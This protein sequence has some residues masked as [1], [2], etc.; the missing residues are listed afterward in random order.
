MAILD[1][2]SADVVFRIEP[3]TMRRIKLRAGS[4]DLADYLWFNIIRPNV[5]SHVW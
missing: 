2:G 3:A 1:D 5:E 4:Q